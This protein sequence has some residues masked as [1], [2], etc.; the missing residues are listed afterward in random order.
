MKGYF[1]IELDDLIDAVGGI[2]EVKKSDDPYTLLGEAHRD[3]ADGL[4]T[5]YH[6]VGE[7]DWTQ[8][9]DF[10]DNLERKEQTGETV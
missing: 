9:Q 1:Q 5:M 2:E 7:V 3:L 10:C 8:L 6:E 4:L